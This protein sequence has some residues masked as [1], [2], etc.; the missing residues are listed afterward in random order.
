MSGI[1]SLPA[2]RCRQEG[3]D[4][5]INPNFSVSGQWINHLNFAL[6]R[7]KVFS[8]LGFRYGDILWSAFQW[9]MELCFDPTDFW[10]EGEVFIELEPL[11]IANGLTVSLAFEA[12]ELRPLLEEI[13]VSPFQILDLGLQDLAICFLQPH[14]L[15]LIFQSRCPTLQFVIANPLAGLFVSSL[16]QGQRPIPD[17]ASLSKLGSQCLLLFDSGIN[18]IAECFA[19]NHVI[20]ERSIY[21]NIC[22]IKGRPKRVE[23]SQELITHR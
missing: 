3:L 15:C 10:Q 14:G 11:G 19:N 20:A 1:V 17:K 22:S 16:P 13:L 12:W 2:F 5:Q 23:M 4:A 9:T 7:H 6:D 18:A 8:G 21:Q